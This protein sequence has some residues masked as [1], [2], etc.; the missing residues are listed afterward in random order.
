MKIIVI[1]GGGIFDRYTRLINSSCWSLLLMI[2]RYPPNSAHVS[3][4]SFQE[5]FKHSSTPHA[6]GPLH[7][8]FLA[9]YLY[10]VH[11]PLSSMMFWM[12][13]ESIV[14]VIAIMFVVNCRAVI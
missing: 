10:L 12:V 1:S 3:D 5:P 6:E 4:A 8:N 9:T 2:G 7:F 11:A 14:M 13:N